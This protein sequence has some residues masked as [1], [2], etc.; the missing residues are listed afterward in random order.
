MNIMLISRSA[1]HVLIS[2]EDPLMGC[3]TERS[4]SA[5]V[6]HKEAPIEFQLSVVWDCG[7]NMFYIYA[8]MNMGLRQGQPP[9]IPLHCCPT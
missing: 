3:C 6:L 8:D 1:S 2:L 7:V 4:K 9:L 5:E